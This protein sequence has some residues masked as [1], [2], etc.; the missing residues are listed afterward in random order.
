MKKLFAA[1]RKFFFAIKVIARAVTSP[2]IAV[3]SKAAKGEPI[4]IGQLGFATWR[5]VVWLAFVL[6][7]TGSMGVPA[8]IAYL[9]L[10]DLTLVGFQT[11]FFAIA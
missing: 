1:I 4:T 7:V 3:A 11:V 9:F 5:L 10:M 6:C 8:V 2:I